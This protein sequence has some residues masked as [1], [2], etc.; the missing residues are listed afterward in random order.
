MPTVSGQ[1]VI[2]DWGTT[3]FGARFT[4][5]LINGYLRAEIHGEGQTG[6][7]LIGDETWH[8]VAVME[9]PRL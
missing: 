7:T 9:P 6:P 8:H 2:T 4:F 3:D 1:I 5:A